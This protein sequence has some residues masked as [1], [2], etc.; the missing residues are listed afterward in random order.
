MSKSRTSVLA[1]SA[2]Y[3]GTVVGA[4]F[5]SGQEILQFFGLLGPYGIP[6]GV[7][8]ILGFFGFGFACMEIGRTLQASS[9][10]PVLKKRPQLPSALLDL[11]TNFFLFGA[12]AA[13][14]S[15][16]GSALQQEFN[17]P[18]LAGAGLM[19][20]LSLITVLFGLKGVISAVSGVVPFLISGVIIVCI[21]VLATRGINLA[22]PP[23]GFSPVFQFWPI[24]GITYVS[25]N[26]IMATPVLAVLGASCKNRNEVKSVAFFGALGLGAGLFLVYVS[27]V[28]SFPES[29]VYEVPMARLA[30][31]L[32]PLGR[33][34]FLA[35]FLAEVY[36]TA[37][38]DLFGFSTRFFKSGE[39]KF[40]ITALL[41]VTAAL[42][43]ASSG[44]STIVRT[45]YPLVGVA[46][47]VFLAGLAL[48][49][50]KDLIGL[51]E[52]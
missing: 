46:G 38:A 6:A 19:A 25:Y 22:Y 43:A 30:S 16:A 52:T 9:H 50:V 7:I 31:Q 47:L 36:T 48:Y 11:A 24:A 51:L 35:I 41:T 39:K 1:L 20:F 15:G 18:W 23:A 28:S 40:K 2:T 26:I 12:L 13:M 37:V 45:V 49:L 44:F 14:I 33:H 10:F 29:L 27:I 8:A 4:G 5:A 34:I 32:H 21:G 17:L 3:I 42:L